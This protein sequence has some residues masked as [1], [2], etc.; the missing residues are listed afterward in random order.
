M[1]ADIV[2]NSVLDALKDGW[3]SPDTCAALVSLL[4]SSRQVEQLTKFIRYVLLVANSFFTDVSM[5]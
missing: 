3:S 2:V 5:H 1:L 4:A